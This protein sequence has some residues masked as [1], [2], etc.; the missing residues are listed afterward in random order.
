MWCLWYLIICWSLLK[1]VTVAHVTCKLAAN[2]NLKVKKSNMSFQLWKFSRLI[3]KG[4]YTLDIFAHNIAIKRWRDI[5]N[6]E[7]RVSMT[8]QGKLLTKLN[9][10]YIR[11]FKILPRLGIEFYASKISMSFYR[12]AILCSKIYSV[13][14]P[15]IRTTFIESLFDGL[16]NW[17][18]DS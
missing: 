6:F 15:L 2:L 8:K 10:R 14:K 3:S 11:I 1:S 13:Y 7:P 9:P 5:D 17:K 12:N 4:L 18:S 16:N